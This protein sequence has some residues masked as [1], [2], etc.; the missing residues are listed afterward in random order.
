LLLILLLTLGG[1][2]L[3]ALAIILG[4]AAWV[5]HNMT[6]LKRVPVYGHP[7]E[8]GLVY[9]DVTFPSRND[10]V[11]LRGWYL[12][13]PSDQRCIV[14]VQGQEHHRNSPGIRA[15]QLGRDLVGHGFSVL[16]FDF[17][18]RGESGGKRDSGGDRE[19]W[20]V[21]G[22]VDYVTSRGIPV[23]RIGLLGFSLGAAVAILVAVKEPRIPAIGC[24]ST[25]LGSLPYLKRVPFYW[26]YL[27]SWFVF[28]IVLAGRLFFG[29]D[30]SKVRPIKAVAKIAQPIFFI[31]GERDHVIPFQETQ[32]L[33]R[34]SNNQ[35]DRLWIVPGVGHV[36][37]YA[38]HPQEYSAK[39][40]SFFQRHIK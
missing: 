30:F 12:P 3:L 4:I 35:E 18:G 31:H 27:P 9:E 2:A 32:E 15:L 16:L 8:F 24:D 17:R 23:E 40:A 19:Q 33:Y 28:P 1:L 20:D 34:L 7:S 14:L 39:V 36:T 22:A 10:K 26:F 21:L 25:F 5:A 38:R 11:L 37:A 6:L 13:A 29:A